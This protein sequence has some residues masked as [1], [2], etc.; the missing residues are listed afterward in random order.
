[1]PPLRFF[2]Q[3]QQLRLRDQVDLVQHEDDWGRQV[4]QEVRD[5]SSPRPG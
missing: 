5:V 1:M 2:D 4:F 3:R